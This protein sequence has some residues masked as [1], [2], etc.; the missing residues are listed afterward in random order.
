[1]KNQCVICSNVFKCKSTLT[2]P[3]CCQRYCESPAQICGRCIKKCDRC[4]LCRS[5]KKIDTYREAIY[6][7]VCHLITVSLLYQVALDDLFILS[8]LYKNGL[9]IINNKKNEK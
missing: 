4:P 6:F 1:M 7:Q 5:Y 8:L 9:R 2:I 3:N